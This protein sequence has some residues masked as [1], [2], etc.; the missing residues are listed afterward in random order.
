[1]HR[2]GSENH[3]FGN[4]TASLSLFDNEGNRK[5]TVVLLD[6][7]KKIG[8][9]LRNRASLPLI[10]SQLGIERIESTA[11]VRSQPIPNRLDGY[12]SSSVPRDLIAPLCFLTQQSIKTPLTGFP[13]HKVGDETVRRR[14]TGRKCEKSVTRVDDNGGFGLDDWM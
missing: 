2:G 14:T 4:R 7:A 12:T 1:M 5:G 8:Y 6:G 11:P 3:R 10:A 9:L 13:V